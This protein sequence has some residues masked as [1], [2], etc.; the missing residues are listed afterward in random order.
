MALGRTETT[1]APEGGMTPNAPADTALSRL[2]RRVRVLWWTASGFVLA[3][4]V[5]IAGFVDAIALA[6]LPRGTLTGAVVVGGGLAASAGPWLR[7]ER[8]WYALG[9]DELEIRRGVVWTTTTVIPYARLQFVDTR[10]GPLER[11]F[12]LTTLVVHTAAPGTT[13]IL[14]G[15]T[16]EAA[17]ELRGRLTAAVKAS[18][19]LSV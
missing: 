1:A 8:W 2:D 18:D 16:L 12:G 9:R 3:L 13:G 6:P 7:Y 14:P 15:L 17:A 11:L 19:E 5:L 10:Q 4:A